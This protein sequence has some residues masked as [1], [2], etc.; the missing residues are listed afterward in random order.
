MKRANVSKIT[1]RT[2]AD[3]RKLKGLVH[4]LLSCN[5]RASR[6]LPVGHGPKTSTI[7]LRVLSACIPIEGIWQKKG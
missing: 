6:L 1:A 7:P 5:S 3:T 4:D 2:G